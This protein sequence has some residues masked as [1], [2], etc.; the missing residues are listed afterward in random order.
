MKIHD[1][2]Y[3]VICIG[4]VIQDIL[5]TNIPM[6]SFTGDNTI[7]ADKFI[8]ATGGDAANEAITLAKYGNHVGLLTRLDKRNVGDMIYKDLQKEK[9][10]VSLIVRADDCET[11]TSIVV[12]H[13]DGSH[14]FLVAPGKEFAP[15]YTEIDFNVLK[16]TK[17]VIVGSLYT[18]GELDKK[19]I[20]EILKSAQESG[21]ITIADMNYDGGKLGPKAL[22]YAYPYI[23]Y[24]MPSYNEAAY[25]SGEIDEDKMADYFLDFGVKNIVIKLGKKGCFFKNKKEKFYCDPYKVTSIDGTGCGDNFVGSF[26]HYLLKGKNHK[27]CAE[28]ACAAGAMNSQEVGAHKFIQ[29][30]AHVREFMKKTEKVLFNRE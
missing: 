18:L 25:V 13:P 19:G 27:E 3:D 6:N 28:F 22:D 23:D 30:E 12:I 24:I 10:D 8:I 20:D 29:S 7:I 4:E 21:A 17:A 26:V 11:V 5:I 16:K 2:K 9:V 14:D 1:K 15:R